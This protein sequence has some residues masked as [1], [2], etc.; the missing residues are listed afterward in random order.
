[1]RAV[2]VC[3]KDMADGVKLED[4]RWAGLPLGAL[5]CARAAAVLGRTRTLELQVMVHEEAQQCG[6][7]DFQRVESLTA[8]VRAQGFDK[9]VDLGQKVLGNLARAQRQL[10]ADLL[11][12]T[13]LLF[14]DDKSHGA[15]DLYRRYRHFKKMAAWQGRVVIDLSRLASGAL[16]AHQTFKDLRA[17]QT[18]CEAQLPIVRDTLGYCMALHGLNR[19]LVRDETR[20]HLLVCV[21]RVVDAE[22][23]IL[24]T[25]LQ[26]ELLAGLAHGEAVAAAGRGRVRR[27]RQKPR[28]RFQPGRWQSPGTNF[29]RAAFRRG[30]GAVC[31]RAG[32]GIGSAPAP[33]SDGPPF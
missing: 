23:M 12:A 18:E 4:T 11:V 16:V 32:G 13:D 2:F 21:K 26:E 10:L 25:H 3:L 6:A 17:L 31:S 27:W 5:A 14:K 15:V 19:P 33:I 1:M 20:L 22:G 30:P 8:A 7:L 28:R 24:P 29:Q 9:M